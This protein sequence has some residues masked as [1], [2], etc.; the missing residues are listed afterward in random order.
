MDPNSAEAK[1]ALRFHGFG[2]KNGVGWTA[3]ERIWCA[4]IGP[5]PASWKTMVPGPE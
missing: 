4:W 1:A 5:V 3:T 2:G